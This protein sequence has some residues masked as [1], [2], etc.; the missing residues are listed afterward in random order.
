MIYM[1]VTMGGVWV[2]EQKTK[3]MGMSM[4]WQII[5]KEEEE[6]EQ[7]DKEEQEQEE[8]DDD[9]IEAADELMK[10]FNKFFT[11]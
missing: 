6:Q 2:W 4:L 3:K 9:E 8:D 5:K 7:E 1:I 11:K 10:K